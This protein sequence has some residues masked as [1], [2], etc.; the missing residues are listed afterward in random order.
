PLTGASAQPASLHGVR[1]S[2]SVRASRRR[3]SLWLEERLLARLGSIGDFRALHPVLL[4]SWSRSELTPKSDIDLLFTGPEERVH[5]FVQCAFKQGLKLRARTPE[6]RA[7]W[8]VGVG[9]FDI[10]ALRSARALDST[11]EWLL[12]EQRKKVVQYRRSIFKALRVEREERRQRQDSVSSVLEPNL[13]FGAG[14]LRDIEQ[15]LAVREIFPEAFR[16]AD[17]YPFVVLAAIKEELLFLRVLMHLLDSGDILTAQ[18]QLEISRRLQFESPRTLMKF[19]QSELERASFYA[20]WVVAYAAA[21]P[22]ARREAARPVRNMHHAVDRLKGKPSL[23]NQFEIRRHIR[24]LSASLT[25]LEAGRVLHR[26]LYADGDDAYLVSLHRTRWLEEVIPDLHHVRGLVQHDHY[27][28]YTADAHLIQALREVQRAKTRKRGLGV[29]SRLT[30]ELSASDWWTLKLTALFH[31]LAKGRDGDHSSE[32]A[33]LVQSYFARWNYPANL[34]EDVRWL[35]ENHL[36]LSTAAFRQN[37]QAQTTWKRLFDRGVRGKRL[38]LLALFTAIDIRATNPDA[39]TTWKAQLLFDLVEN[40]RSPR[41]AQLNAHLAYASKHQLDRTQSWLLEVDPVLLEFLAPRTLMTDLKLASEST[42]SD[43]APK[44]IRGRD[45]RLWVRFHRRVDETGVFLSF[46]KQLFGFGLNIQMASVHTLAGIGVYDWFCLRTEKPAR[47]IAKWLAFTPATSGLSSASIAR[48]QVE[49][50]SIDLMSQ[51]S[52]EWIISF[53]GKNQRGLLLSAAHVLAEEKLSV[54]WA[55][56]HTW[57]QQ[58]EDVFSVQPFGEA[59]AT[60]LRLRKHF[61]I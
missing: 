17:P 34:T 50:Q 30:K 11:T 13:K 15:A 12:E 22:V 40:L 59:E 7:D 36:I 38:V 43:L 3:F 27:H 14:G 58:V 48:P 55:R 19:I 57:G 26:A 18:D 2:E 5:E 31:D 39:W 33:E 25:P 41:A 51:E 29:V 56:A 21:G 8:T 9:S 24:D 52:D 32:G 44:V 53:R 60:V 4:G 1:F 46:V 16:V 61:G 49:F 54:R 37:P 10:L 42:S 6:N 20:D 35:V 23:L 47:Q 28:R 45:G